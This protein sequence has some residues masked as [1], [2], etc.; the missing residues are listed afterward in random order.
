MVG[1]NEKKDKAISG[2]IMEN[3][4]MAKRYSY[5]LNKLRE[6]SVIYGEAG[7]KILDFVE[8][9]TEDITKKIGEMDSRINSS[10][11]L[12]QNT[13]VDLR[14]IRNEFSKLS[15][16]VGKK[17]EDKFLNINQNF[18]VI[19]EKISQ[20]ELLEKRMMDAENRNAVLDERLR[21]VAKDLEVWQTK[22]FQLSNKL[23]I[24]F[25][26]E[27]EQLKKDRIKSKE[28]FSSLSKDFNMV[29][30]DSK[31]KMKV[32]SNHILKFEDIKSKMK[33]D[34][35]DDYIA[36]IQKLEERIEELEK[37]SEKMDRFLDVDLGKLVRE[38]EK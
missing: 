14:S 9:E 4:I 6:A 33:K 1:N 5:M 16:D 37:K 25:E 10:L 35:R 27:R 2:L 30:S 7:K 8:K 19:K 18:T 32:L 22:F 21:E 29:V 23:K 31:Q 20:L 24:D 28:D 38:V 34:I 26:K 36:I 17:E 12:S 3:D 15:T 13:A 11:T